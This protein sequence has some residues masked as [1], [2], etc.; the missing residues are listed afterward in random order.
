LLVFHP[1]D[2]FRKGLKH[3]DVK[4]FFYQQKTPNIRG[5]LT[6]L[7]IKCIMGEKHSSENSFELA[8]SAELPK[9]LRADSK[10]EL[11]P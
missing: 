1:V 10:Q 8:E 5:F 7:K 11:T 2:N 4:A 9:E 3:G 6:K